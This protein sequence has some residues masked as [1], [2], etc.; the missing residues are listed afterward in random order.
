MNERKQWFCTVQIVGVLA[1][2]GLCLGTCTAFALPGVGDMMDDLDLK[3]VEELKQDIQI[4][5]LLNVLYL[6]PQQIDGLL[7]LHARRRELTGQ[8]KGDLIG[9]AEDTKQAFR[10]LRQELITSDHSN[11]RVSKLAQRANSGM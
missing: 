8:V 10:A 9:N 5:N 1:V 4:L 11:D 3:E 6:T 2:V 7:E